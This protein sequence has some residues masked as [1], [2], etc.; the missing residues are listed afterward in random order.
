MSAV[1][2]AHAVEGSGPPLYMVHG[3]GSRKTHWNALIARFKSEFTC[4]SFD[5]RG[6]GES[7]VPGYAPTVLDETGRG[8]GGAPRAAGARADPRRRSFPGGA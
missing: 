3:I 5:L 2:V 7:P 1:D 6:H 8:P 4:V